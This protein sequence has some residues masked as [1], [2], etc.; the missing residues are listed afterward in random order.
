MAA[1]GAW[2]TTRAATVMISTTTAAGV[3]REIMVF[4]AQAVCLARTP[5]IQAAGSG[6]TAG[7]CNVNFRSGCLAR[8]LA[9]RQAADGGIRSATKARSHED[10]LD[11]KWL[12]VFVSSY[13]L[14]RQDVG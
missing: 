1:S 10:R 9:Q 7:F 4:E 11:E 12:R 6:R 3:R 2:P 14:D 8:R 5:T 13:R